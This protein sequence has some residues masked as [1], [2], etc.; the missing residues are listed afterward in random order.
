VVPAAI[1]AL[2]SVHPP[3]AFFLLLFS[4][5]SARR[6]LHLRSVDNCTVS[7]RESAT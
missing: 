5:A 4:S 7:G 3:T 1:G 6:D 2:S